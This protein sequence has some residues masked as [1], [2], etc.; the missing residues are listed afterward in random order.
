MM[1]RRQGF[2][3]IELMIAV[4]LIGL[5]VSI[6]IPNYRKIREKAYDAKAVAEIKYLTVESEAYFADNG[7]YPTS[8]ADL[9]YVPP[10]DIAIT[11]F[12]REQTNGNDVVH[13]HLNHTS[14]RSYYHVEYPEEDIEK[15]RI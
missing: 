7:V 8:A 2:T 6:A 1:E 15:R 13:I 12:A 11:R 10:A 9:G 4:V 3:L 14:S 5:L